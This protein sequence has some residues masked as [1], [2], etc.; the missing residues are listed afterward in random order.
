MDGSEVVQ[1]V[2]RRL[3]LEQRGIDWT[4]IPC[5]Q[6][7]AVPN[8]PQIKRQHNIEISIV[9]KAA[10]VILN[11]RGTG[12]NLAAFANYQASMS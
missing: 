11:A 4:P 12:T 2:G 6:D 8:A 9:L 7:C 1:L 10:L 5:C 3:R